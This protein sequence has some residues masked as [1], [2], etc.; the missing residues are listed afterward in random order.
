MYIRREIAA[1][2]NIPGH[3]DD[4]HRGYPL[5]DRS[6]GTI[7]AEEGRELFSSRPRT[8]R[9]KG[10]KVTCKSLHERYH[11][12][13]VSFISLQLSSAQVSRRKLIAFNYGNDVIRYKAERV[14]WCVELR[15]LMHKTSDTL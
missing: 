10:V 15:Y 14:S 6:K 13:L 5:S 9:Q 8:G 3:R 7:A 11:I 2:V 4:W 1:L 12:V